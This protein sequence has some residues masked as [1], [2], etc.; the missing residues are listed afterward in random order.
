MQSPRFYRLAAML[1][2][3]H[4]PALAGATVITQHIDIKSLLENNR[5]GATY[6]GTLDIRSALAA[7]GMA[8]PFSVGSAR[9]T[10]VGKAKHSGGRGQKDDTRKSKGKDEDKRA[11]GGDATELA[12]VLGEAGTRFSA[13]VENAA[14]AAGDDRRAGSRLPE[15]NAALP[16]DALA[17]LAADG[18]LDFTVAR[19]PGRFKL[20]GMSFEIETTAVP[21]NPVTRQAAAV[22]APSPLALLA[23]GLL[24]T[25]LVGRQK[26][27][28]GSRKCDASDP[29]ETQRQHTTHSRS[30]R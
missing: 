8:A 3:L 5:G 16:D 4:F 27:I 19:L 22:P 15:F 6:A 20:E 1:L 2:A 14:T 23:A 9:L 17:D 18:R 30:T 29:L 26:R 25:G 10:V 12:I 21:A 11:F 28:P 7:R 24:A 13:W